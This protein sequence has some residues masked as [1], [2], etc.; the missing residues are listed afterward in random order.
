MDECVMNRNKS[1]KKNNKKKQTK[2]KTHSAGMYEV[3]RIWP[4]IATGPNQTPDTS[5]NRPARAAGKPWEYLPLSFLISLAVLTVS[6]SECL[7]PE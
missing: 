5:P 1:K 7:K 4:Y 2:M 6:L 3:N